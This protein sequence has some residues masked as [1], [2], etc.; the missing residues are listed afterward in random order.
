[1][2]NLITKNPIKWANYKPVESSSSF[3]LIYHYFYDVIN[4]INHTNYEELYQVSNV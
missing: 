3:C 4:Q 1:M 2:L